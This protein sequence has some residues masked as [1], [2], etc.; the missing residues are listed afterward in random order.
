MTVVRPT[1]HDRLESQPLRPDRGPLLASLALHV[2]VVLGA[3]ALHAATFSPVEF[4][5]YEINIVSMADPDLP[6]EIALPDPDELVVEQPQPDPPAP[7]PEPEPTP[8]V[9]EPEPTPPEPE[10]TRDPPPPDPPAQDPPRQDPPAQ[11]PPPSDPPP[12]PS[13]TRPTWTSTCAWRGSSGTTRPTTR[14]SWPP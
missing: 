6:E 7:E 2:V 12:E 1:H 14:A 3:W 8:P 11:R 5:T 13:D 4:V 10:P 9:P